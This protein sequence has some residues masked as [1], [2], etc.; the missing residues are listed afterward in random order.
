MTDAL[1]P[2]A[3]AEIRDDFRALE[4]RERLELLL[5]FSD[6]LPELPDRYRDAPDAFERVVE[7]Q[8]PVFIA[9]E[10]D[11]ERRAHVYAMAPAEA[12]TTR[13]FASIVAQGLEGLTPDEVAAI[14]DDFPQMLGLTRAISPLRL[15]G[16][17]GLL[18]HAK[19]RTAELAH[20]G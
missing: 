20:A 17:T 12:P 16:M 19:R 5:E 11:A 9:V 18:G 2:A 10:L 7:C 15:R 6:E 4:E 8:A 13:G 14:P 1:L 3:L